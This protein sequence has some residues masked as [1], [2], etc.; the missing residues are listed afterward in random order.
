MCTVTV[1]IIKRQCVQD[2]VTYHGICYVM[3]PQTQSPMYSVKIKEN[4]FTWE[5]E[6]QT[7]ESPSLLLKS[8]FSDNFLSSFKSTGLRAAFQ[9]FTKVVLKKFV[10]AAATKGALDSSSKRDKGF[11][12]VCVTFTHTHTICHG[13][14]AATTSR[15]Y[16][17]ISPDKT[18]TSEGWAVQGSL[19]RHSLR[20]MTKNK[21]HDSLAQEYPAS[22]HSQWVLISFYYCG[23]L[24]ACCCQCLDPAAG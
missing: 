9:P 11:V 1:C 10:A 17:P 23:V 16:E 12:I 5:T 22:K 6:W 2:M 7:F 21:N 20:C 19:G 13:A 18:Y 8:F 3:F 24:A 15:K 4:I 14:S